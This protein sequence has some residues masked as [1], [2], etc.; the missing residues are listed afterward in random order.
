MEQRHRTVLILI[1]GALSALG[2]LSIDMYLPG[3]PA[4]ATD[5]QTSVDQVTYSLSSFF[6]GISIG[7]LICGP[8]LDRY[9]RK[10]PLVVGLVVYILASVGCALSPTVEILIGFRL[11][12]ALGCCV[13]MVAPRA[14]TRDVFPLSESVRVFSL[15]ILI[16]GVSP[17]LAPTVGSYLIASFGWQAV[18]ITTAAIGLLLLG[19][20]HFKLKESQ[21]ADPSVSLKAGPILS[22]F[23]T[24]LKHPQFFTYGCAGSIVSAGLFA[25]LSGSPFVF[26]NIYGLS[27]KQYGWI[28]GLIAAGLITCSQLNNLL[29]KRFSSESI[30]KTV[31]LV[32]ASA[33]I[34]FCAGTVMGILDVYTTIFLIFIFLSCQGFSFPNSAALSMAPFSKEAGSASA[35]MGALQMG[36][37]SIASAMVGAMNDGTQLPMA[38]IM[39]GCAVIGLI[40]LL[41]GS[42][43]VVAPKLEDVEEQAFEQIENY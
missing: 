26:M 7:Q 35:L 15:L 41:M 20:V 16:L 38:S 4:M 12:Q 9:G 10:R 32:Q 22:S 24:V 25:Y 29:V 28:F 2:P 43:K 11:L 5:L 21:P 23:G 33:G 6:I 31:M 14:I 8:L 19:A 27:E 18:F 40:I 39:T 17:I 37:G 3:F 36:F 13:A 1:L 30:V 34:L 42:R